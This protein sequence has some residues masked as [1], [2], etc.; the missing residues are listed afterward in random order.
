M[1]DCIDEQRVCELMEPINKKLDELIVIQKKQADAIQT[2]VEIETT[3]NIIRRAI[4]WL[5]GFA[6]GLFILNWVVDKFPK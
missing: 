6:A 2:W 5:S 1:S 4:K 3:A